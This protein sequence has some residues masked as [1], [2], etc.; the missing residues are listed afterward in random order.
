MQERLL[1]KAVLPMALLCLGFTG[2]ALATSPNSSTGTGG[3]THAAAPP[4]SDALNQ[5]SSSAAAKGAQSNAKLSK[6]DRKFVEKAAKGGHAEV[7]L[8]QYMKEHAHDEQVKQ[9]AARMVHDHSQ[10][11]EKLQAIA[12]Q[13]NL[14]L[15]SGMDEKSRKFMDKLE[16]LQGEALDREYMNHMV[17]DHK[18]DISAF[19]KE[20]KKAKNPDLRNF[21]QS[22]VPTLEEHLKLAKAA[23]G[24]VKPGKTATRERGSAAKSAMNAGASSPSASAGQ[25]A[26]ERTAMN[27]RSGGEAGAKR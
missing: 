1:A 11:D 27:E 13:D 20:A 18:K 9:F 7:E 16:K 3:T 5:S 17:K 25:S 26:S 10:A 6:T 19:R 23:Q 21:A 8:G 22:T 2:S 15:P 4:A 12:R 24:A 14:Q